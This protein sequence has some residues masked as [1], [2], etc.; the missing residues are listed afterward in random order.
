MT[1]VN[2]A[3]KVLFRGYVSAKDWQSNSVGPDKKNP[4]ELTKEFRIKYSALCEGNKWGK[5]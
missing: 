1:T 3:K 2:P 5:R 4:R